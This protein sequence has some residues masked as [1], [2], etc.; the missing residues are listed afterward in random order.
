MTVTAI[1]AAFIFLA[2]LGGGFEVKELRIPVI[3]LWARI[4]CAIVG[5]A[6]VVLG[7]LPP[8]YFSKTGP[9]TPPLAKNIDK[10]PARQPTS[11]LE[12]AAADNSQTASE[13]F[14]VALTASSDLSV[15]QQTLLK[16]KS[17]APEGSKIQIYKRKNALWATVI[18]YSDNSVALADLQKYTANPDWRDAYVVYLENWC[19]KAEKLD[20]VYQS[21]V[22]RVS[23]LDC[24]L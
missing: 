8:D 9:T 21:P 20:L 22:G 23:T 5:T 18:I 19:P 12:A 16:A 7:V 17:V 10:G 24:H 4:T 3:N 6:L 15:A 13:R 14:G 1:G 11:P 2:I